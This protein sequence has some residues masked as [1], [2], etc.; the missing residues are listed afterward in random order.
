MKYFGTEVEKIRATPKPPPRPT[1]SP[2]I[3]NISLMAFLL[4]FCMLRE[5]NDTDE[6][7]KR[8][9]FDHFGDEASRLKK[10]YDYNIKHNLPTS[11]ILSRLREIGAPVPPG[12]R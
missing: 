6:L 4:Y 8:D 3:V 7:L 5:E 11:E 12:M 2:Y 1:Y 10:A 9:L